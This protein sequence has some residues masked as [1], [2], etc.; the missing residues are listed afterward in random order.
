MRCS[1][2]SLTRPQRFEILGKKASE[3]SVNAA[4]AANEVGMKLN[5]WRTIC[6][7]CVVCALTVIGL[8]E[9]TYR[10]G[11]NDKVMESLTFDETITIVG[12]EAFI[13]HVRKALTLLESKSPSGY[14][15]VKKYIG[16]IREG[17]TSGMYAY[18]SPPTFQMSAQ[19]AL[20]NERNKDYALQWCASA[21]AHDAYHSKKYHDYQEAHGHSPGFHP[22][23]PIYVWTGEAIEREC[24]AFQKKVCGE[25][26]AYQTICEYLEKC[27]GRYCQAPRN[28]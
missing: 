11:Q 2:H 21:I 1:L 23:P 16:R 12:S 3:S 22:Y 27:D 13:D 20:L 18:Y 5:L 19:E 4:K 6:L 14:P 26:G 15:V 8:P 24:I 28:W 9:P 10:S 17:T 7:V 25:I